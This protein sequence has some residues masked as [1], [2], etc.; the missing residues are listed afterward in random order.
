MCAWCESAARK[1]RFV[2]LYP[3]LTALEIMRLDGI[4]PPHS[5]ETMLFVHNPESR[6]VLR[7]SKLRNGLVHLG[8]QDIASELD[9]ASTADDAV[10]AYTRQDPEEVAIRVERHLDRLVDSLT[11]WLLTPTAQGESFLTAL[12]R[13]RLE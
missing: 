6:W 3:C 8:L 12:H 7:Q 2:A 10:R 11:T 4:H 1:H 5:A 9:G 13:A